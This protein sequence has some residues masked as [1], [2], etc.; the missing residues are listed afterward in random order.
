MIEE[1]SK[2]QPEIVK[3][4]MEIVQQKHL[5]HAYLFTGEVGAGELEVAMLIA[6]R[7]FCTN[8]IDNRPCGECTECRRILAREHPDV[9]MTKPDGLSIKVDQIRHIK[10]EFS[11][12]AVEGNQKVF[13]IENAEKMTVGAANSLLKFIEEPIGAV[14]TFLISPEKQLILPTIVSRT[15][16]VDFNGVDNQLLIQSLTNLGVPPSQR[17]LLLSLTNSLPQIEEWVQDDWFYKLSNQLIKWFE[18]LT[19]GNKLALPIVQM[20]IMPLLT[21]RT[22]QRLALDL[23]VTIWQDTLLC[24]YNSAALDSIRFQSAKP[25]ISKVASQITTSQLLAA[26]DGLLTINAALDVNVGF[27]NILEAKTLKILTLFSK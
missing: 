25:V 1:I 17:D 7:L 26:I 13:I 19:A 11:T 23:I 4:F 21:N 9:V 2:T 14:T 24:K 3:Q 6:M 22:Q 10:A 15:Q 18:Y 16:V 20:E 12:S 5:S 27:Q 8:V